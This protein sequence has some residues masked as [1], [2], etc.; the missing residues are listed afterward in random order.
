MFNKGVNYGR[1]GYI[2]GA[3]DRNLPRGNVQDLPQGRFW[4]AHN[5]PEY[6]L[7]GSRGDQG[8]MST[9]FFYFGSASNIFVAQQR[10]ID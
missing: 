4:G 10:I 2:P 3:A 1:E 8:T 9:Y 6:N 5:L 7:G